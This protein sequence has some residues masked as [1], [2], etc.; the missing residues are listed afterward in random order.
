MLE[1]TLWNRQLGVM[2]EEI[3]AALVCQI[4]EGA[5]PA[6]N[7]CKTLS[8]RT[9]QDWQLGAVSAETAAPC[10]SARSV[11]VR[12]R[13]HA[14]DTPPFLCATLTALSCVPHP[15]SALPVFP[16]MRDHHAAPWRPTGDPKSP[17]RC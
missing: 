9:L 11:R 15:L 3:V 13:L 14:V 6:A 4:F 17:E 12:A 1:N 16:A 7:P 5:R 2:S 8:P 10:W